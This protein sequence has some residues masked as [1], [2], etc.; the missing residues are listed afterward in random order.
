MEVPE[1]QTQCKGAK[2][3][4]LLKTISLLI[5]C[6]T[7]LNNAASGQKSSLEES[8]ANNNSIK[9]GVDA[10]VELISIVFRLAGNPEYNGGA[11]PKPNFQAQFAVPAKKF[12]FIGIF[13]LTD[14]TQSGI[15]FLRDHGGFM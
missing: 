12:L 8:S 6:F 7:C 10:R 11:I 14:L 13:L 5:L 15:L 4:K 1:D 9:V 3:A 2:M